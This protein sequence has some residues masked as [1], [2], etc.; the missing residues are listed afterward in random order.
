MKPAKQ[1]E[2]REAVIF[3]L[4]S[5]SKIE[6]VVTERVPEFDTNSVAPQNILLAEDGKANQ[7]LAVGLLT[8]WGHQVTVAED[9]Q[10]VIQ[11]WRNGS[12]DVILM[13]VQMPV[14]DGLAATQQIREFERTTGTHIPIIAMTAHALKGDREKCLASGMDD[15][16]S[17]PIRKSELL[18]ALNGQTAPMGKQPNK[19]DASLPLIDWELALETVDNDRELLSEIYDAVF[20]E[21]PPLLEKLSLAI[22]HQDTETI[23]RAAHSIK[24]GASG[25]A[26]I[27]T[28]QA[29]AAI[30]V[31][32]ANRDFES[33][34]GNFS[35][36]RESVEQLKNMG[37]QFQAES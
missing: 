3:A 10:S 4:G 18:R 30:E 19:V 12:F 14:L 23:Q 22:E 32:V 31:S 6:R 1:S 36:L 26:A 24:G 37:D 35:V 2:I 11:R 28:Q 20:I 17:K 15:Y 16:I 25:L 5:K 13:D 9:G 27:R 7:K 29:A 33:I 8:K 34:R 21:I